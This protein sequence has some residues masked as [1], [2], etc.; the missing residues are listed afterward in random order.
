[1]ANPPLTQEQLKEAL[2]AWSET[3]NSYLRGSALLDMKYNK[4][5]YRVDSAKRL[6]MHLSDGAQDAIK[7]AGLNGIEAKGGWIHNYDQEGKKIGTTRWSAEQSEVSD[8][9]IER[10]ASRM[11]RLVAA[12]E[13]QRPQQTR[14]DMLNFV[15]L[16]DVHLGQRVGSF[17][18]K[19]AVNRLQDGFRDVIGRAPPAETLVILNGGDFTEANDNSA[20]TPQSKHPLAV[21]MDFDDLADIAIDVTVDLIEYGL[22]HSDKLIYQPLKG[23]H[24]PAI[25]A[26]I[27]QGLRMRY[28]D[29]PR[30]EMKD[31][32]DIFTHEWEGNLL[33]GIHG[34]QKTSKPEGLT[35]AIASRHAA[36]W[37]TT[38]RRELWRGHLH[39]E[40]TVNVPGMRVYQVNPICPPGRYANDNLFTGE[41]DIQCITYGKGGGRRATTVHIFD[42]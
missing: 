15:P 30:F 14:S 39:K 27:R 6:G 5:R 26:A 18:T 41:S 19:E 17:G 13:V 25:A 40:I 1:M 16:F 32:H 37:G 28:R 35:L 34:D 38:K 11:E 4:F 36:A 2:N 31:G 29:N 42:D 20:L 7:N 12:P 24:D 3:G 21:D 9:T 10:I 33:A 23:N 22:R 8:D